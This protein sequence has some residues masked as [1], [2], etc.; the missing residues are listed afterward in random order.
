[1]SYDLTFLIKAAG[2]SWEEAL[3]ALGEDAPG[4]LPDGQA[5]ASVLQHAREALGEVTESTNS[6]TRN[7]VMDR[8]P[9]LASFLPRTVLHRSRPGRPRDPLPGAHVRRRGRLAMLGWQPQHRW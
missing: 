9:A 4:V 1:M 7:K 8:V 5:W 6:T 3:E 2:Q